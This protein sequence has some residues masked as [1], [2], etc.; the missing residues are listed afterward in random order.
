[1]PE[2]FA[3]VGAALLDDLSR[4]R[5]LLGA[6]RTEPPHLAGGWELPGG[7]VDPGETELEAL[8]RELREELGV[9]LVVGEEV[10]GPLP[11]GRWVLSERY[12]IR[13]WTAQV[14][15]VEPR[16]LEDHDELRWLGREDLGEVPWLPADL[17]IVEAVGRLL[18]S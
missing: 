7:K 15:G 17:P 6:R 13:V 4:P 16:A 14:S 8:H 5:L 18:A 2:P 9:D 12:A 3:V 1:M 11:D 10:T